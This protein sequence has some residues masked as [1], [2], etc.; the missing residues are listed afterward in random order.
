MSNSMV[1]SK[2]LQRLEAEKE[3]FIK[4][5]RGEAHCMD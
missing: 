3:S 2:I 1:A 4:Q 5:L